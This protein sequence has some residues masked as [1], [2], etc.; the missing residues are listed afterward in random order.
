MIHGAS[1]SAE[2]KSSLAKAK[3]PNVYFQTLRLMT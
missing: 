2:D 3:A 1:A